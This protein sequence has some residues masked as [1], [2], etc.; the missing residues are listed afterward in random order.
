M[1]TNAKQ[2]LAETYFHV[3]DVVQSKTDSQKLQKDKQ[4]RVTDL[5][6][7]DFGTVSYCVEPLDGGTKAWVNNAHLLLGHVTNEAEDSFGS[8]EVLGEDDVSV[9]AEEV[10][11]EQVL[12]HLA[13][14]ISDTLAAALMDTPVDVLVAALRADLDLSPGA[15]WTNVGLPQDDVDVRH[16]ARIVAELAAKAVKSRV[17]KNATE[18][19]NKLLA[20]Y[21][22]GKKA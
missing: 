22:K 19:L 21:F 11:E 15:E 6:H 18:V 10:T 5:K 20:E 7:G 14:V 3:G 1:K 8:K 16:G 4:Y 2:T 17:Q 12:K 9:E 13:L